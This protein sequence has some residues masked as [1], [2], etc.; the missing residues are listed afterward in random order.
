[1]AQNLLDA[2]SRSVL[3]G[4]VSNDYQH[5]S[6]FPGEPKSIT[7]KSGDS[8]FNL[9]FLFLN[10]DEDIAEEW[11]TD[12]LTT[13][14]FARD[15]Y[16]VY[17]KGDLNALVIASF[18][19]TESGREEDYE[20]TEEDMLLINPSYTEPSYT[21]QTVDAVSIEQAHMAPVASV[22][23]SAAASA[24]TTIIGKTQV[25]VIGACGKPKKRAYTRK[26]TKTVLPATAASKQIAANLAANGLSLKGTSNRVS[27]L[28]ANGNRVS[29]AKQIMD[30]INRALPNITQ[31]ELAILTDNDQ[32][33]Q[34][35]SLGF[36]LF[37]EVNPNMSYKDQ[38][39]FNGKY[40]YSKHTVTLFGKDYYITNH[41]FARNIPKVDNMFKTLGLYNSSNTSD[42]IN[43]ADTSITS[44]IST[45]SNISNIST[46]INNSDIN[47]IEDNQSLNVEAINID[48]NIDTDSVTGN[49]FTNI[50]NFEQ[51][52]DTNNGTDV[53][54]DL[55]IENDNLSDDTLN[56]QEEHVDIVTVPITYT[57]DEENNLATV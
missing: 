33:N 38:T 57:T 47:S 21:E 34:L 54:D 50:D 6:D 12:Y 16:E 19:L 13:N 11:V 1:M 20:F 55:T 45:I 39:T 7:A 48:T 49:E 24:S 3:E 30:M 9:C 22:G 14:G 29:A 46:D 2:L 35:A 28:D 36:P 26:T 44:D 56:E 32:C 52:D 4:L 25:S 40:R 43:T 17:S 41:L 53:N 5:G 15:T 23:A 37:M 51:S 10:T 18:P 42:E 31:K 8:L 27:T